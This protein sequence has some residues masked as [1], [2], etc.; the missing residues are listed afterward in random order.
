MDKSI[1]LDEIKNNLP[2]ISYNILQMLYNNESLSYKEIVEKLKVGQNK[3]AKEIARL[4]G[5]L[6][7]ESKKSDLDGRENKLSLTVYGQQL[8]KL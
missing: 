3:A 2:N 6:L 8:L 5:A 4:E 1:T 7:I